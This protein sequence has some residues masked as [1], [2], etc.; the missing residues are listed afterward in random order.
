MKFRIPAPVCLLLAALFF[1][2]PLPA[3][4]VKKVVLQGYW[5]DYRNNN[6]PGSWANYLTELAPRLR[7]MGID[8]VWIPPSIKNNS[9]NSVGFS[10]FDHYDLGDKFQ[11]GNLNTRLGTKDELMRMIAVMHANGIE[12]IQDLVL[13]HVDNA[14]SRNG[15][16]GQDPLAATGGPYDDGR[17]NGFKNF[18]YVSWA[19]PAGD[20]SQADYWSRGGRWAK[21]FPNFYPNA[22]AGCCSN[23]VNSVFWG[24][25][26]SYE[27]G[28]YGQS[29]NVT[30]FNPPQGPDYMRNQARDW[31]MWYKKQT[32]VDGYRWDAVKHFPLYVQQDL[33]WN[34]KYGVPTWAQGGNTMFNVAE[35]VGG[36]SQLDGYVDGVTNA[37][38]GN[39]FMMGTFDFNLRAFD[40]NGGLY[41]LVYGF[42]G[43]D[44][45][46]LPGAQQQRRV[47]QYGNLFVHRTVPFV[48]NHDTFRPILDAQGNITG[49]NTGSELSPH[50]DPTEPRLSAAYAVAIAMDGNPQIFFE[51]LFDLTGGRRFNHQP[52]D[53]ASLPARSDLENLMWCHQV[54]DFKTGAYKVRFHDDN[55][56]PANNR[57]DH[58]VI[59]RSG[60]AIIGINDNWDTWQNDWVDSDFAPGTVLRDYSGANGTATV[61]VQGDRRVNINTPPVNPALNIAGRKGYSVWAPVG[62]ES[63]SYTP[64]RGR[65]TTQEWEM[66]DDLGDSHCSSLGQGG[67]LPA[68]STAQRIAGKIFVAKNAPITAR[69]YPTLSGHNLTLSLYNLRG[70]LLAQTQGSGNLEFTHIPADTGWVVVKVR[71]TFPTNPGQ[72]CFVNVTYTAPAVVDI[73]KYPAQPEVAIWTGN[74]DT[75][76]AADCRNWEQGLRPFPGR[77][78]IVPAHAMTQPRISGLLQCRNLLLEGGQSVDILQ[79]GTF[80][81]HGNVT[82]GGRVCGSGWMILGGSTIQEISEPLAVCSLQVRNAAGVRVTAPVTI[83]ERLLLTNGLITLTDADLTLTSGLPIEG[84]NPAGRYIV[85]SGSGRV[86]QKLRANQ[87]TLFPIGLPGSVPAFMEKFW[88]FEDTALLA[89]RVS[90]GTTAEPGPADCSIG[91]IWHLTFTAP[92]F[93]IDSILLYP[94]PQVWGAD[95]DP[96]TA[97]PWVMNENGQWQAVRLTKSQTT[98]NGTGLGLLPLQTTRAVTLSS[99]RAQAPDE[100]EF[101]AERE[102]DH[103]RL[104]LTTGFVGGLQTCFLVKRPAS[105]PSSQF[106][107]AFGLS[108]ANPFT[109]TYLDTVFT[110]DAW[111]SVTLTN[112]H[113]EV[114]WVDSVFLAWSEGDELGI[115]VVPNPAGNEADL[116]LTGVASAQE[117]LSLKVVG[118]DGR[119]VLRVTG[120]YAAIRS[121][122][123]ENWTKL[124]AGMY[125]LRLESGGK[126]V[127][128]KAVKGE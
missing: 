31:M 125:L 112:F 1:Y 13:N 42:G 115:R 90:G 8:A 19:H 103:A 87:N 99:C 104:R 9:P 28:A 63:A 14:G 37:N 109:D 53:P 113:N 16:G 57:G 26:I 77:D 6:Y 71:N 68:N 94:D 114:V 20:E 59:E 10:P 98:A 47:A 128:T 11:K 100:A 86:A 40:G 93:G 15:S 49:W 88:Q 45:S 80:T 56:T 62:F 55:G 122:F 65:E 97:I 23:D 7:A 66:A 74:G 120:E 38:G 21:N 124:S 126:G 12:V 24:P 58:L 39:E 108:E 61:V 127:R 117:V 4:T 46:T 2:A 27:S 41:G 85:T 76:D 118:L 81:V 75:P 29:S 79:G 36:G 102:G 33:S 91:A 5:W 43:F 73:E 44:L 17:T 70:E 89:V 22:A 84:A 95:F 123:R 52:G 83:S 119:E 106:L 54:L 32:G 101:T 51:D 92:G 72:R 96:A 18:R 111:Y 35:F 25:D 34:A 30:G 48:N 69:L 116:E 121:A 50:I 3:Q 82:G 105:S 78:M 107:T 67:A 60:K 64:P 110:E